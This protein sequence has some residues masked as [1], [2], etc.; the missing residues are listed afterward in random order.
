MDTISHLGK[1]FEECWKIWNIEFNVSG[2]TFTL[3]NVAE[4]AVFIWVLGVV[5][6]ALLMGGWSSE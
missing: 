6:D 4:V 1:I 2:F 5:I 3:A